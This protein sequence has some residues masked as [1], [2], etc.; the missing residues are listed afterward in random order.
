MGNPEGK[1][2]VGKRRPRW[3]NKFQID[4]RE[5]GWGGIDWINVVQDRDQWWTLVNVVMDI[6]NSP[7]KQIYLNPF[8]VTIYSG[9][10]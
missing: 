5:M 8:F 2:I 4:V 6:R 7:P 10:C 3:E 1:R 9:V